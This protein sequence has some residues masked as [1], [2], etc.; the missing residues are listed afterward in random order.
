MPRREHINETSAVMTLCHCPAQPTACTRRW[1]VAW[2]PI[3]RNLFNYPR[4]CY[5]RY[6]S[7]GGLFPD[8]GS[9]R[10]VALDACAHDLL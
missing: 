3:T 8:H 4:W 6:C 2:S 7:S 1:Q 9:D 10:A 5:R